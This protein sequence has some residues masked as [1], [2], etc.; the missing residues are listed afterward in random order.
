MAAGPASERKDLASGKCFSKQFYNNNANTQKDTSHDHAG[1]AIG[2]IRKQTSYCTNPPLLALISRVA[3]TIPW[4][5]R[6]PRLC[7]C[8][9]AKK[10]QN[11]ERIQDF[12]RF[13]LE[14]HRKYGRSSVVQ[15]TGPPLEVANVWFTACWEL[16]SPFWCSVVDSSVTDFIATNSPKETSP[17]ICRLLL[18]STTGSFASLFLI[19]PSPD[20]KTTS[21]S[22]LFV[23]A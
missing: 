3:T 1:S 14:Y 4:P 11:Q 23:K 16:F 18:T 9:A 2:Q 22:C 12:L 19:Q 8:Q 21:P 10:R 5:K 17:E 7:C 15:Y 6:K 13:F 20:F